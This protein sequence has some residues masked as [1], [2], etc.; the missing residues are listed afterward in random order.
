[1][2]NITE[3]ER[4]YGIYKVTILGGAVNI[5]LLIFKFVA[6]II[7]N[8]SA[9]IADAFHSLSD[10]VTDVI[11]IIFVR[12]SNKPKDESHDYGHGKFETFATLLIG[13]VLLFVGFGI[14]WT[15]INEIISVI[16]GDKI[17]SPGMI[18]LG[19]AILSIFFKEA[20]Y[21]Y[22]VI[23]SRKLKSDV[24]KANAWHHRS[25]GLTSI[26]TAIGIGGAIILGDKWL[27]LDPLAA[28][29][30]SLFIVRMAFK[31]MKPCVDELME[32]SLSEEIEQEIKKI[33]EE[34]EEADDLHNLKTRKIGNNYAIEFH[35]R[36]DGNMSLTKAHDTVTDIE[37]KLKEH[38]GQ[39]THVIIHT[40]PLLC[41]T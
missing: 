23:Q 21:R 34:C 38:Y 9:M 4:E 14:A 8:S 37:N 30:V 20:L 2:K 24:L 22:T 18:A 32:R 35:V 15:G 41:A 25:D 33:V 16:N 7:G 13:C 39:N 27:I 12:I 28:L 10:F 19:A 36:L 31:L 29:F 40:E 17:E 1:M 3:K 6:G 5:L 26:G 11:V